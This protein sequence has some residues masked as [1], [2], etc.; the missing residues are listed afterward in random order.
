LA[1]GRL[2]AEGFIRGREDLLQL[3]IDDAPAGTIMRA[4]LPEALAAAAFARLER[5]PADDAPPGGP[6]PTTAGHPRPDRVRAPVPPLSAFAP[7]FRQL[8]ASAEQYEQSGGLH[9]AAL[10]DGARLL[11]TVEEVGRHNAVDKAIGLGLLAGDD[12]SR[13]GLLLSARVSGAMAAKAARAGLAWV[14]SRSVP[15]TMAVAVAETSGLP[16]VARAAGKEPYVYA[17]GD[18]GDA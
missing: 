2:L 14:A 9:S 11:H 18:G 1:A 6:Q 17:A 12:L 13:L 10:C 4:Q 3:T 15:T 16:I 8:F 5:L 7:L